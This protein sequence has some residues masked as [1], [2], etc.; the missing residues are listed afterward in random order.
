MLSKHSN[1]EL[2][3]YPRRYRSH[4]PEGMLYP[5]EQLIPEEVFFTVE[6]LKLPDGFRSSLLKEGS[7]KGSMGYF[8]P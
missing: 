1:T 2:Y 8:V 4:S 3:P 7:L 5:S 6:C